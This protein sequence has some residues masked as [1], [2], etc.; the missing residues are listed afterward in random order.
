V[1]GTVHVVEAGSGLAIA[2]DT[3]ADLPK[4]A[5]GSCPVCTRRL[6]GQEQRRTAERGSTDVP[7]LYLVQT[8]PVPVPTD[9]R[10]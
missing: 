8:S 10:A 5:F 9:G 1:V 4:H 2:V 7:T 6:R 3:H